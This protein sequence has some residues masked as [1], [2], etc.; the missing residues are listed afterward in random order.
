MVDLSG[1]IIIVFANKK[2]I[3]NKALKNCTLGLTSSISQ[4]K[5]KLMTTRNKGESK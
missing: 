4:E 2:K 3:K 1:L 5:R